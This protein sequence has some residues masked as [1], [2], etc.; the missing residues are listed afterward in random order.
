MTQ[1]NKSYSCPQRPYECMIST[2]RKMPY[3]M[4]KH[5][6]FHQRYAMFDAAMRL[7]R[8]LQRQIRFRN[9]PF[10]LNE[11]LLERLWVSAI[12]CPGFSVA[13]KDDIAYV[14]GL[15]EERMRDFNMPRFADKWKHTHTL[16]PKPGVTQDVLEVSFTMALPFLTRT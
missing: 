3:Y 10:L 8:S 9:S 6:T 7:I 12:L 14:V 4:T 16:V 1:S 13:Q 15:T 2:L 11:Q 5:I